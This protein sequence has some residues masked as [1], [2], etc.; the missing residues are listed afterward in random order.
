MAATTSSTLSADLQ[1]FFA[2]K[3]LKQAEYTTRLDDYGHIENIPSRS[4]KTISFTQYSDLGLATGALTE[5]VAPTDTALAATAINA[6]IDQ[7][8]AFVTLTDLAELTPKHPVTTKTLELLGT[9]AGRTR[10]RIIENTLV[11]GTSVIYAGSG[12]LARTDLAEADVVTSQNIRQAVKTL[13]QNGAMDW[14]GY[15]VM[16]VDPSVSADLQADSEFQTMSARRTDRIFKGEIGTWFGV[17][18]VESNTLNTYSST[19]TVHTSYVL[20]KDAYAVT[21]LQ[22]LKTYVEGPGTVSDPLHQK[23]TMGWKLGFKAVILNDNF[24]TRIESGT[25]YA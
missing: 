15:F 17:R 24:M 25:N 19:T 2:K 5:G 10:D 11:A 1:T 20:G 8:G 14:D 12:N 16:I 13:R 21:D 22:T 9:Q 3:L 7:Y 6:T 23:R 4:S 18:V